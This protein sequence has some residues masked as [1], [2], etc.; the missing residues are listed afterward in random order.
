MTVLVTADWHVSEN[1]RDNYRWLWLKKL[2]ALL[3]KHRV[4]LLLILGDLTES[5]GH[6]GAELVNPLVDVFQAVSEI[7][8]TVVSQGNHDWLSSPDTPYFAFLRHL[9]RVS[10]VGRA[11]TPLTGVENV[12]L[13]ILR[14]LGKGAILL[15]HSA[16]PERDWKDLDFKTFDWAFC[17]QT[18][19]GTEGD[20]GFQ[21]SGLPLSI[22]PSKLKVVS[23]DVHRPQAFEN[24]TYC[25]SPYSVDFGD[26]FQSRV[27]LI[28]NK[29]KI[30]SIPCTGPQKR[31]VEVSTVAELKSYK[32]INAGDILKV[33][34][35]ISPSQHAEW[36]EIAAQV[37]AWGAKR[38]FE[39]HAVQP[40]V[41]ADRKSIPKARKEGPK[42]S[43]AELLKE[44]AQVRGVEGS[45][46]KVGEKFL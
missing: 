28:D 30:E 37:R 2:P 33:R 16:N 13:S 24:L 20:S 9:E 4:D 15:P 5:K 31:L 40:V 35:E 46:L 26:A 27:L 34:V 21:L 14:A 25:G 18:F 6:H 1:S 3:T 41:K 12:P 38:G 19:A 42:R 7:C 29:G 17:H 45:T 43:D 22:F 44:Y 10:W 39:V 8:P 11:P 36:P 23:G 32:R